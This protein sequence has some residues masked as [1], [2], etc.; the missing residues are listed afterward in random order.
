V[1][2]K[3]MF[4]LLLLLS[5]ILSGCVQTTGTPPVT[6]PTNTNQRFLYQ[7]YVSI[8]PTSLDVIEQR[9]INFGCEQLTDKQLADFNT[10]Q[11]CHYKKGAIG[12]GPYLLIYPKGLGGFGSPLSYSI[13]QDNKLHSSGGLPGPPDV[14]K[15]KQSVRDD[16][17]LVGNPI[18]IQEDSWVINTSVAD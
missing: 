10:T 17:A 12:T 8:E 6:P 13:T 1:N 11:E 3:N 7:S 18:T 15:F 16:V 14:E 4:V 9:L 5:I 2:M